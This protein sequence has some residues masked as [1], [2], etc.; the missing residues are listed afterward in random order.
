MRLL[1]I[2]CG[3]SAIVLGGVG[4]LACAAA[5]Y[6]GWWAAGEVT[7]RTTAVAARLDQALVE[8]DA[9]LERIEK[10]VAEARNELAAARAEAD[11]LTDRDPQLPAVRAAVERVLDRLLPTLDRAAATAESL[12]TVAAGLRAAEDLVTQFGGE[13]EQPS[14]A[15]AAADAIDRA[16]ELL[17]VPQAKIQEVKSAAAVQLTRALVDLAREAVLA[18]D[19]L[20]EGLAWCRREVAQAREKLADYRDRVIFWARVVAIVNTVLW[21]WGGLGQC[22]LIGWGRRRLVSSDQ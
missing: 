6:G 1:R 12:R 18:S 13:V 16:A 11:K 15:R 19:R 4:V 3:I 17:D 22:C 7:D 20:A 9:R 2:L 5:V 10:R 8:A 14:R 21:V